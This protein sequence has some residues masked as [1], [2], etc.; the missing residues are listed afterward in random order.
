MN[1]SPPLAPPWDERQGIAKESTLKLKAERAPKGRRGA[2]PGGQSP[3]FFWGGFLRWKSASCGKTFRNFQVGNHVSCLL[4]TFVSNKLVGSKSIYWFLVSK[5]T[6]QQSK[7]R[8]VKTNHFVEYLP[9]N[10][11]EFMIGRPYSNPKKIK[12]KSL[13]FWNDSNPL[14][15]LPVLDIFCDFL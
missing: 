9:L 10:I 12:I 1:C 5:E 13:K 2:G 8:Q 4:F 7:I 14:Y 6:L 3:P 15:G 11:L